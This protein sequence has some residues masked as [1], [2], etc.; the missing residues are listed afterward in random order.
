[1]YNVST[2]SPNMKYLPNNNNNHFFIYKKKIISIYLYQAQVDKKDD[3]MIHH[4]MWG[5]RLCKKQ[6][7]DLSF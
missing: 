4:I 2:L 1:M 5:S 7:L 6:S 3:M